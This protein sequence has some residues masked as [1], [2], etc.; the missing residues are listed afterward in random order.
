V[1]ADTDLSITEAAEQTGVPPRTLRAWCQ[2]WPGLARRNGRAW[3]I[4]ELDID[5]PRNWRTA[6][7]LCRQAPE[8]LLSDWDS[9]FLATIAGYAHR[10]S[11]RQIDILSTIVGNVLAGGAQ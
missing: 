9:R 5:W 8:G 7:H 6:V 4:S 3:R 11:D 1:S 10:P 2:D